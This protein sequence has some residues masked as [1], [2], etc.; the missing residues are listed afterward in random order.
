MAD[1]GE[2]VVVTRPQPEGD[3][4]ARELEA[5]GFAALVEPMLV[6][7]AVDFAA[8]EFGGYGGVLLTSGQAAGFFAAGV[9]EAAVAAGFFEVPVICVGKHTAGAA[10]AAGFVDVVSVDGTGADLARHVAGIEGAHGR[11]FLHICGADVAYPVADI[12]SEQGVATDALVVYAAAAVRRFS[13]EFMEALLAG[14][15][16]VVTFFSKRTAEAFVAATRAEERFADGFEGVFSGIKF[17]SISP[18]VVECVRI[19]DGAE[20]YVSETPDRAGMLKIL[21]DIV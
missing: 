19:F 1:A 17:L 12:L 20:M 7:N 14:R 4:Y 3:D 6:L 2:L 16:G 13:A 8:A 10:R 11:R 9:S 18:S 5:Q 21:Q 15:I